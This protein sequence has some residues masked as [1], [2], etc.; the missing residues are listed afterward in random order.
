MKL[1]ILVTLLLA[2]AAAQPAEPAVWRCGADG[3]SYGDSPCAGGQQVAV[4]DPRSDLQRAEARDAAKRD[5]ALAR[6]LVQERR[7]REA[8][9]RA[10]GPGLIA[11]KSSPATARETL[12]PRSK[13][14]EKTSKHDRASRPEARGTSPTADRWTRSPQ[15]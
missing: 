2:S 6:Q 4:A 10:H 14:K 13:K 15:G 11:I 7:E 1:L 5:Q 12:K 8:E 9:L 3:R